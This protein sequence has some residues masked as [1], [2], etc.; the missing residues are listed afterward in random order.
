MSQANRIE[1]LPNS[2]TEAFTRLLNKVHI[3]LRQF[4]QQKFKEHNIDITFEMVQVMGHLWHH[5][6]VNQQEIANAIIKDKTSLTYLIDNLTRRNL[7][8]R[9]EDA[10]DRRNKL[11]YLTSEGYKLKEIIMVWINEMYDLAGRD[12]SE[13]ALLESM[14]ILEKIHHNLKRPN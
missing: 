9:R 7:V 12:I 10:N 5:D 13:D 3:A 2:T 1:I 14:R 8:E 6:G 11:I 4:M